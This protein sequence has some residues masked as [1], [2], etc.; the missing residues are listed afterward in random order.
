MATPEDEIPSYLP[1]IPAHAPCFKGIIA[2]RNIGLHLALCVG[3]KLLFVIVPVVNPYFLTNRS[4]STV[5]RTS[6]V[7][8]VLVAE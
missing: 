6:T 5:G 1:R 2:Y 7:V 8:I 4:A 3:L